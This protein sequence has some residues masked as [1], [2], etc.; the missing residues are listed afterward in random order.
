MLCV[1]EGFGILGIRVGLLIMVFF[2]NVDGVFE[3]LLVGLYGV[4]DE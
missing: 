2:F 4:G 1:G 3:F